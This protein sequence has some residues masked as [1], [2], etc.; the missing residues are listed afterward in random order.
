MNTRI[1]LI[2]ANQRQALRVQVAL[3]RYGLTV[4]IAGTFRR[5][6][7]VAQHRPPKAIVLDEAIP[8]IDCAQLAE[9]LKDAPATVEI[10]VIVLALYG[11]TTV[12]PLEIQV[13]DPRPSVNAWSPEQQIVEGLRQKGLL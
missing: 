11:E 3:L 2:S 5:G 7:A 6:I 4:E 12:A 1:L 13:G 8:E 10:P 9:V